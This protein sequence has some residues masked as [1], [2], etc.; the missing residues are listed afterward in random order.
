MHN[1]H[2]FRIATYNNATR[3]IIDH[4][5]EKKMVETVDASGTA[6]EVSHLITENM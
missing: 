5:A 3:P 2:F 4:Y 1:L 6:E